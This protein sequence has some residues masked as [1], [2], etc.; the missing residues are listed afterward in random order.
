MTKNAVLNLI[1]RKRSVNVAI[2]ED[3]GITDN[4]EAVLKTLVAE[5]FEKVKETV[6]SMPAERRE[7]YVLSREEGLP[8]KEIAARLKISLKTVEYHI[9][10]ALSDIK[11]N[12]I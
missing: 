10:R 11:K 1:C 9:G 3:A 12:L 2:E 7:V 4:E 6:D 5:V 8:N